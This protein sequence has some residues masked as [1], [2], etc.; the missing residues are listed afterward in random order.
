MNKT[1]K[2][3]KEAL[4]KTSPKGQSVGLEKTL[5]AVRDLPLPPRRIGHFTM[6]LRIIPFISWKIWLVQGIC[7]IVLCR[8]LIGFSN[9][10]APRGLVFPVKILCLLSGSIPFVSIPFLYKS[11][12]CRMSEIEMG[13]Y[14]SYPAQ[15]IARLIAIALGNIFMIAGGLIVSVMKLKVSYLGA[16][17]YGMIPFLL[18]NTII[19]LILAHASLEKSAI[20]Y[21]LSYLGL[22]I[23]TGTVNFWQN[24]ID[25]RISTGY[26]VLICLVLCIGIA[27]EAGGLLG[28]KYSL[29]GSI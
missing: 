8:V 5:Q 18:F 7:L 10:E 29:E 28:R 21:A 16:L 2:Y 14:F 11:V 25:S 3:L 6:L 4:S 15:M 24:F 20:F 17:T 23:L 12:R 27:F 9:M 13:T 1:E 19:M 22:L 26:A